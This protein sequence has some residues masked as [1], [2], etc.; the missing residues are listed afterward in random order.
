[1]SVKRVTSN[2]HS[3]TVTNWYRERNLLILRH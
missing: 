1:M 2:M 3:I